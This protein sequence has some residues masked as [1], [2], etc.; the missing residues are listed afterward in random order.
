MRGARVR[1]LQ[2]SK[3][4][5]PVMGGIESVAW[6][7]TEGLNRAGHRT[8]VLCSH[9][10]WQGT[11]ERSPSGY[12]IWRAGSM[13]RLLST[14]IAPPMVSL[15]ARLVHPVDVLH[16]HMPDP[17]AAIALWLVR[18]ACKVVVH[19]HSD[20]VRQRTAMHL[21]EPLQQWVLARA[22]AIIATS[23]PYVDSSDALQAWRGKVRCVPIGISDNRPKACT[24]KAAALRQQ[25]RDYRFATC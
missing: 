17:M 21:Y 6:E 16:V 3:F 5:P 12:D 24:E 13:G 7:L 22:D 25:F 10:Q 14:S 23:P 18:P 2:L 1:V 4:Y 20:V 15:L 19:W 9:Q 8:D 11:H